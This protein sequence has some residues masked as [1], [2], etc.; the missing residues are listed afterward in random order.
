MIDIDERANRV[1]NMVKAK[2]G[3]KDKSQ[4]IN[5]VVNEYEESC[6]EPELRPEFIE[7]IQKMQKKS[8]FSSNIFNNCR[9]KNQD[10]MNINGNINEWTPFPRSSK[11]ILMHGKYW[12][13]KRQKKSKKIFARHLKGFIKKN[14]KA[15]ALS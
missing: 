3:L 14:F 9:Q 13:K 5:L 4:A 11:K 6:L 2:Y 7:K 8:S 15:P 12:K 1:L 10:Y